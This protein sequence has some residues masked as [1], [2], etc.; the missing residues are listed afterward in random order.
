MVG[1]AT[2]TLSV[3]ATANSTGLITNV[4][5]VSANENDPNPTNNSAISVTTVGPP[6]T[7]VVDDTIVIQGTSKT[8]VLFALTLSH[9]SSATVS[10][11]YQTFDGT[12][13]A[14]QDYDAASGVV[15]FVP[16]TTT[17]QLN[18]PIILPNTVVTPQNAFYLNLTG[19]TNGTLVRTQAVATIIK[20]IFRAVSIVGTSVIEGNTGVTNAVFNFTLS[21]PSPVPVGVL[22]EAFN[23][24]AAGGSDYVSR[25]GTLVFAPGVTNQ[26]LGIPVLGDSFVESDETFYV[27]LSQPQNAILAANQAAGTIMNDD[28]PGPVAF[29]DVQV[30]GINIWLQFNTIQGRLY[31]VESSEDLASGTW[32]SVIDRLPGTGSLVSFSDSFVESSPSRFYRLLLLP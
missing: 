18:L 24:T 6:P 20:Q 31:R 7:I 21:S 4:A 12:A 30:Q 11:G 9:A 5:S 14:G 17:R 19:A 26:M 3:N 1:R 25:S 27:V 23:G 15:T 16:G 22:Y 10:V 2:A 32:A 8:A 13:V 28:L 29:L